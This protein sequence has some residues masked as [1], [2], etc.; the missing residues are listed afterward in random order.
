MARMI[1]EDF[2]K[3]IVVPDNTTVFLTRDDPAF[4]GEFPELEYIIA[5][6]AALETR[7]KSLASQVKQ[8]TQRDNIDTISI[9]YV[10][11]RTD[12]LDGTGFWES[13]T[14]ALRVGGPEINDFGKGDTP[15]AWQNMKDT[16][17]YLVSDSFDPLK[18][19]QS[20]LAAMVFLPRQIRALS[21]IYQP[22][23]MEAQFDNAD[24]LR[25][26]RNVDEYKRLSDTKEPGNGLNTEH[27]TGFRLPGYNVA[28]F[29]IGLEKSSGFGYLPYLLKLKA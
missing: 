16:V 21:L 22:T 1:P 8:A 6:K 17:L 5:T 10:G 20:Y 11:N 7:V 14:K 2:N 23:L 26:I 24:I 25:N 27:I 18:F 4:F 28:G 29:G 3:T 13:F 15:I 9:A 19:S 12:T